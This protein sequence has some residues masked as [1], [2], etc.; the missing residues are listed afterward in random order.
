MIHFL[1]EMSGI[2]MTFHQ[3]NR[4]HFIQ[5]LLFLVLLVQTVQCVT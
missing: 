2:L 1:Y 4:Y 3:E 5:H